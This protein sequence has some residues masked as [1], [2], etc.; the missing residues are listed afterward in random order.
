MFFPTT[1]ELAQRRIKAMLICFRLDYIIRALA[2]SKDN[3]NGVWSTGVRYPSTPM[4]VAQAWPW[5]R[6]L[7]ERFSG[8]PASS[9][10][11]CALTTS[12]AP[13][14]DLA[15][16]EMEEV[17]LLK[18][19]CN[20]CDR[21]IFEPESIGAI[22]IDIFIVSFLIYHSSAQGLTTAI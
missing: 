16:T 5:S 20:D 10:P 1:N 7:S 4:C 8:L 9:S 19:L 15:R 17:Y 3:L 13:T 22:H 14:R 18:H 21:T 2:I 6:K 12:I 11:L